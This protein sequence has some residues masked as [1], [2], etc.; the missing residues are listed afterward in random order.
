MRTQHM[1][2]ALV[3]AGT[4]ALGSGMALAASGSSATE[5][6]KAPAAAAPAPATKSPAVKTEE[7]RESKTIQR[8][9]Q[10]RQARKEK[11]EK[12]V[13]VDRVAE[14]VVTH[15]EPTA[16]PPALVMKTTAGKEA[17]V[18]GV[19]VP[20]K[21]IIRKGKVAMKLEDIQAGDRVWM[22]WD[23]LDNRLV[24]DRIQ[25]LKANSTAAVKTSPAAA[26]PEGPAAA[27]AEVSKKSY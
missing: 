5:G 2:L 25:V 8:A 19:D 26:K 20:A 1:I 23:R 13:T 12:E 10:A 3:A 17:L 4:L 14:G 16:V 11:G 18:V 15:V 9:E 6:S 7:T 27:K 24:A 21:T 22:R